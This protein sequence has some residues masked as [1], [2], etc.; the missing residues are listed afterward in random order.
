M[1]NELV[2]VT[3][4]S[5]AGKTAISKNVIDQY[6]E[7]YA[8]F[9]TTTT[10][11]LRETE[12]EGVDYYHVPLDVFKQQLLENEFFE[13]EEVYQDMWYGFSRAELERVG[14]MSSKALAVTDVNG[15]LKFLGKR[16]E[17][18]IDL[19]GI[20]VKVVYIYSERQELIDRIVK[21][22]EQGNRND[23]PAAIEKRIKRIDYE[24]A[25]MDQFDVVI[26]NS[27]GRYSF[28]VNEFLNYVMHE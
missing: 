20:P 3:G 18:I 12:K 5:G 23:S 9:I 21:D 22:V 15:A 28:A 11:D 25:Q 10:R 8:K 26:E 6:P 13:A 27:N 17:G 2:I 14:R 1:I 16:T 4:A 19:T 24:L 7:R